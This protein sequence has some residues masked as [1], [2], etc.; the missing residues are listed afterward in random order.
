MLGE[1]PHDLAS[2][3]DDVAPAYDHG[4]PR[5]P[6]HV[7]EAI[8]G[9]AGG[10]RLL[11]VGA[12]T[13]RISEPLLRAGLDVV[14]V[15][16]LDG[17]RAV[18]ARAIGAGRALAGRAETLPLPDASVDGAVCGDAWHWFDAPRAA[19]ELARVVRPGGGVVVGISHLRWLDADGPRAPAWSREIGA[20]LDPLWR[21][22]DHPSVAGSWRP[23]GLDGHPDF[24]P[25]HERNVPFVHRTDREAT[26]AH[27]A[28]LSY[29]AS[30][31]AERRDAVL[32]ALREVLERHRVDVLDLPYRA[33]LW[34][35]RRRPARALR[36]NRRA[37]AS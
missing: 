16:P 35:T 17:M 30:L 6:P 8:A 21:A 20:I 5:Y 36:A 29:I 27:H 12:G 25:L 31:P 26:M 13:G 7:I 14:A 19:D 4:R 28:S 9:A 34:I 10:P 33:E 1:V 15:E 22:A 18:L 23:A 32:A 24:E 2:S 11:D 37:A 3:F